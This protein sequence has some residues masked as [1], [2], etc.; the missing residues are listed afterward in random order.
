MASASRRSARRDQTQ[1]A[2]AFHL[3]RLVHRNVQVGYVSLGIQHRP[4]YVIE[5]VFTHSAVSLGKRGLQPGE[6]LA[7]ARPEVLAAAL[8]IV[9]FLRPRAAS[10]GRV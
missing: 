2:V 10:S 1:L 9:T 3:Q 7:W 4:K 8:Q 6:G 5:F